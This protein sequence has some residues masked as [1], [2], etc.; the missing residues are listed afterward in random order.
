MNIQVLESFNWI[1]ILLILLL[2]K[3]IY[4]G[5]RT[6]LSAELFK[7]LGTVISIVVG[8]HYYKEIANALITYIKIPIWVS[9]CVILVGIV[10]I[11]AIIVRY[12][13]IFLLKILNIQFVQHLEKVGGALVGLVRG[14]LIGGL[15]L[16]ALSFFPAEYLH[17]SISEKSLLAPY[18]VK[19]SEK[20]YM[21][22]IRLIPSQEP[23]EI[24]VA[25]P[26][27]QTAPSPKKKK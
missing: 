6:G 7:L 8:F 25:F 22:I 21:S 23:K 26:A 13:V 17:T 15:F 3:T 14:F 11:S 27:K 1:D 16:T 20:T 24:T 2:I 12:V 18:F 4:T 10:L 9:E 19:S 5:A